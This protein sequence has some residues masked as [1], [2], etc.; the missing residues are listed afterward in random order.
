MI[1]VTVPDMN[2]RHD[3][4]AISAA[5]ADVDGVVALQ[6]DLTTKRVQVEGSDVSPTEIRAAI[7]ATGYYAR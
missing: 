2:C 5:L 1:V 3:V 6:I 7:A 4:R